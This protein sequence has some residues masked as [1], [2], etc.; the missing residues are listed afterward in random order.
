A[1]DSRDVNAAVSQAAKA[2]RLPINVVDDPELSTFIFPAII[3]RSPVVVAVGSS[4]NS[5]VLARRVRQQIE[6]LLPAR[7]GALAGFV[8]D[9]RDEVKRALAPAQ[10][11][12]F[13]ERVI[14]GIVGSRVLAGDERDAN[15]KFLSELASLDKPADPAA[16]AGDGRVGEVYLIG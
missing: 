13:W 12:P 2:R 8:G 1:T 7:L 11:R 6:A 3:D 16:A 9:R 10:R 5:P 14:G 15:A 4:G